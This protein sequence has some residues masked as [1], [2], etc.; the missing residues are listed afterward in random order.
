VTHSVG[1]L[2]KNTWAPARTLLRQSRDGGI[3]KVILN[4]MLDS[5]LLV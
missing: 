2:A 5:E 3:P 4:N 1:D